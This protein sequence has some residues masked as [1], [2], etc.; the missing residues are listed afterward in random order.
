MSKISRFAITLVMVVITFNVVVF[1]YKMMD[2]HVYKERPKRDHAHA[3][4]PIGTALPQFELADMTGTMRNINEWGNKVL[5]IN[6]WATWCPPCVREIPSLIEVMHSHADKGFQVIGIAIDNKDDVEDYIEK[7][8]ISYPILIGETDAITITK[9]L[10]N[11]FGA[12][13]Y[14]ILVSRDGI[15][16]VTHQGELKHDDLIEMITPLL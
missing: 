13:P 3:V 8:G 14:S 4:G 6:F 10:G 1:S 12:L 15:I 16:K 7:M 11:R 2:T 9:Q 5:L